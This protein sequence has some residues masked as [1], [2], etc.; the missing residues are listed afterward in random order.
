MRAVLCLAALLLA[1][2]TPAASQGVPDGFSFAAGGDLLG[3]YRP[4]AYADDPAMAP[5]VALFRSADLGY[6]NQEGAMFDLATTPVSPAAENGGG[7]PTVPKSNAQQLRSLGVTIVSKANNHATDWGHE[8]LNAT[9]RTLEA[10]GIVQ[11]GSGAGLVEA[12]APAYVETRLGRAALVSTAS[13]FPPMSA[14]GDAISYRGLRSLPR[15]GIS[16]LRVR[17]VRGV[18]ADHLAALRKAAG[19]SAFVTPDRADQVRIGDILYRSTPTPGTLSWETAPDDEAALLAS[20]RTARANARFVLFAI[21]AHETAG[22]E[23]AGPAPFQPAVLHFANEA[24]GSNDPRPADFEPRLFRAV[25]DAGADAVARTGPHQIGGIE[26]YRGKPIFYGLGSLFFD[27]GGRRSL[28]TAAGERFAF[29]DEWFETIVP[30]TRYRGGAIDEIRIYP[31]VLESSTGPG[32]G[33]PH[34]AAADQARRILERLRVLSAPYGTTVAIENGIGII[35]TV[36]SSSR[37][38]KP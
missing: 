7:T 36:D 35:R 3:P 33:F 26:I 10:A 17:A 2:S 16:P 22:D 21:H 4:I 5:V 15:P 37:R 38:K 12:T 13:T 29:P 32:G 19:G 24:A 1:A 20:V 11:A 18:S 27:F 23:D 9:L 6:A 14:A 31:F 8:G 28:A 25:I 30:V 34:P